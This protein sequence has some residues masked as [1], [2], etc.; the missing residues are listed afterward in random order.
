MD[1]YG[2]YTYN[3]IKHLSRE[4]KEKL[5]KLEGDRANK[6]MKVLEKNGKNPYILQKTQTMLESYGRK[7]F[8]T[9]A[10]R[11]SKNALNKQLIYALNYNNS[12]S[13]SYRNLI[14]LSKNKADFFKENFG[15]DFKKI[16]EK[17][18]YT[19]LSSTEFKHM[20][21]YMDSSQ[22]IDDFINLANAGVEIDEIRTSFRQYELGNISKSDIQN[23][24]KQLAQEKKLFRGNM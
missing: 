9:S 24:A 5:L 15:I 7:T 18:F 23:Y 19:F 1:R 3:D 6:K 16:N 8:S 4:E 20:R 21:T 11:L 17:D 22:L 13:G 2:R 12:Q 14:K 10:K